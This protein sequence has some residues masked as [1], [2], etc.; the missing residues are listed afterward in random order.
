MLEICKIVTFHTW[1]RTEFI[2]SLF[3]FLGDL[4]YLL[5]KGIFTIFNFFKTTRGVI[6]RSFSSWR[7]TYAFFFT[8]CLSEYANCFLTCVL[9]LKGRVFSSLTSDFF[10]NEGVGSF[11]IILDWG[12]GSLLTRI[13]FLRGSSFSFLGSFFH[14]IRFRI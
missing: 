10:L 7:G 8:F 12:Y 6:L 5:Y 14:N 3:H 9:F 13:L 4:G 1:R 11:F 2:S